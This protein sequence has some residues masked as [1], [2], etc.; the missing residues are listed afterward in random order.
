MRCSWGELGFSVDFCSFSLVFSVILMHKLTL[1]S[2]K[3]ATPPVSRR[4]PFVLFLHPADTGVP[5][6][7]DLFACGIVTVTELIEH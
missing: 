3:Q 4:G 7:S 5:G 2:K 6:L 1:F